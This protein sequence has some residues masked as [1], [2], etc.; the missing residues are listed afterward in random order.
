MEINKNKTDTKIPAKNEPVFSL[1]QLSKDCR[2]LFGV[3]PSTFAGAVCN[4]EKD[5]KMT[6][7]DMKAHIKKWLDTPLNLNGKK[8]K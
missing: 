8:V 2:E 4:L 3:S 6:V 5:C 1:E 7:A